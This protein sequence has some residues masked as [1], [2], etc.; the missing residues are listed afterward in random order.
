MSYP[1]AVR[2]S[3]FTGHVSDI[4]D[5]SIVD[6]ERWTLSETLQIAV[7]MREQ[8]EHRHIG[9]TTVQKPTR[10]PKGGR[11]VGLTE[12]NYTDA[13]FLAVCSVHSGAGKLVAAE[14]ITRVLRKQMF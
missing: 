10:I 4:P 6:S 5:H 9:S 8:S 12:Q 11:K 14:F 1:C 2:C 3:S 13:H 7:L